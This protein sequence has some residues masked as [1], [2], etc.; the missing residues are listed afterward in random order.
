MVS[1][2]V[3]RLQWASVMRGDWLVWLMT[4]GRDAARDATPGRGV[5]PRRGPG[6]SLRCGGSLRAASS[7]IRRPG[8]EAFAVGVVAVN[9]DVVSA[10]D[11][12]A[13]LPM[14]PENLRLHATSFGGRVAALVS[15]VAG[16]DAA[17]G[18]PSLAAVNREALGGGPWVPAEY[19]EGQRWARDPRGSR[20]RCD[21]PRIPH[22]KATRWRRP[23]KTPC[24]VAILIG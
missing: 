20:V 13:G 16:G 23:S 3:H 21:S 5:R 17:A 11:I 4:G 22:D 1:E 18:A 10:R 8:R 19:A 7:S 15:S 14:K 12:A 2:V 24:Q 9:E 6:S